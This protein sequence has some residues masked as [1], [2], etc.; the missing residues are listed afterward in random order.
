ME[1]TKK[2][3]F[4]GFDGAQYS[5]LQELMAEGKLDHLAQLDRVVGYIGGDLGTTTQQPTNSGPGWSTLLTGTWADQHGVTSNNGRQTNGDSIFE[6]IDANVEN[7]RIASVVNWAP[8]NTGHFGDEIASDVIDDNAQGLSDAAATAEVV[9]LINEDDAP[10]FTF[11]Q[12]DEPDV[13]GHGHGTSETLDNALIRAVE[14]LGEMLE[15]VE[16]RK[17]THPDEDWMVIVATDHGRTADGYNHGGQSPTEREIFIGSNKD[18]GEFDQAVPATSLSATILDHFG[19]DW[20]QTNMAS[21][22]LLEGAGD[23]ILPRLE[24][25]A[26]GMN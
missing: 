22:S 13:V 9:R 3:L 14:Q 6:L 25:V 21:G 24:D 15:A 5:R 7:A 8:I 23:P 17:I 18:L 1:T 12:L 26:I 10:D 19:I 4:V 2:A 20:T 16:A 11:V